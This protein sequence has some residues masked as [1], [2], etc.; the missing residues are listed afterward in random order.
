MIMEAEKSHNMP[1]A[2]RRPRE[3]GGIVAVL[4][5]G[6]HLHH[7]PTENQGASGIISSPSPKSREPGTVMSRAGANG[8]LSSSR[9]NKSLFL[10]LYILLGLST[11][12][13]MFTHT[14]QGYLSYSLYQFKY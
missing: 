2:S 12:W 8:H 4:T 13:M 5:R 9:G 1:S 7:L 10:C 14:D 11:D 6:T 3:T